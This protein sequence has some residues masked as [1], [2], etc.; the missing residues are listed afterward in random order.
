MFHTAPEGVNTTIEKFRPALDV[1]NRSVHC[2]YDNTPIIIIIII[3][4]IT[5]F[6][7]ITYLAELPV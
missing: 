5:F 4:I 1:V 2:H 3:I 6:K 7:R